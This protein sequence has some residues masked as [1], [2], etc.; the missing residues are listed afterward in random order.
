[1]KNNNDAKKRQQDA[2]RKMLKTETNL[3]KGRYLGKGEIPADESVEQGLMV[4]PK[5]K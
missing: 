3:A 4:F 2:Y 1:M 5:E